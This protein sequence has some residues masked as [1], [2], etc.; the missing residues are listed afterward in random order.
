MAYLSGLLDKVT[1]LPRL[2]Q[3]IYTLIYNIFF[4]ISLIKNL[5]R[6]E[7]LKKWVTG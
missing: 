5:A 1:Q 2:H 3:F 7:F 4:N 6:R